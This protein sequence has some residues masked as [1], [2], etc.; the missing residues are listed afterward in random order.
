M[1]RCSWVDLRSERYIAYHDHRWGK[2]E[3]DDRQLFEMLVLES[4]QAGLSWLT[5]LNIYTPVPTIQFINPIIIPTTGKNIML[6]PK[7]LESNFTLGIGSLVINFISSAISFNIMI[8]FSFILFNPLFFKSLFSI[9]P[10]LF[11][12][13]F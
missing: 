6:F 7:S 2:P 5:I 10:P 3:H 4:F 11:Y 12:F 9:F 13:Y 8:P 1:K